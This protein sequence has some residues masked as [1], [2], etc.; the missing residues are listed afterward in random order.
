VVGA[1]NEALGFDKDHGYGGKGVTDSTTG[2]VTGP[3]GPVSVSRSYTEEDVKDPKSVATAVGMGLGS[4][5]GSLA[6]IGQ[7]AGKRC[8]CSRG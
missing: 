1:I 2:E 3:G 7:A 8:R 6:G 4:I 5:A